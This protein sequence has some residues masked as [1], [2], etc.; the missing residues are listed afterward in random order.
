MALLRKKASVEQKTKEQKVKKVTPKQASFDFINAAKEFETSRIG[1]IERSRVIAWRV[2]I[3]ACAVAVASTV[4]VVGLTPLKEVRPYVIRVDNNTGSTDIVT[5]LSNSKSDYGDE[6]SKFFAAQYVR[7]VEG[8]DWY[9]IQTQINQAMMFSDSNMQSQLQKKFSMPTAPHKVYKSGQRINIKINN[10]SIIDPK[11][12]LQVRFTKSIE[13]MS[14]GS[15]NP[16]TNTVTPPPEVSNHIATIGYEFVNVP[17]VDDV[18]LV[19]PLG[20]T[21]KTYRVDDD[22]STPKAAVTTVPAPVPATPTP[23]SAGGGM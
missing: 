17:T 7:L 19:N 5:M 13:P 21:V 16:Q 8:Y 10:V 22:A 15:Y 1:D 11:G 3:G 9:T 12:I 23:T 14:G 2:A 20:F 6:V 4:A 18:R